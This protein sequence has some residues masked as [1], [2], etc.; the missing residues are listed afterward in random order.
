MENSNDFYASLFSD[1][2]RVDAVFNRQ[3]SGDTITIMGPTSSGKSTAL[4]ELLPPVSNMLLGLNVGD[5]AQ[6]TLIPPYLMLNSRLEEDQVVIRC[7]PREVDLYTD[8]CAQVK[9]KLAK[10]IYDERDL[11]DEFSISDDMVEAI[12]NPVDRRYHVYAF[13]KNS[14][15]LSPLTNLINQMSQEIIKEPEPIATAAMVR[16][17]QLRAKEPRI[18]ILDV[19]EQLIDERFSSN[20]TAEHLLKNWYDDLVAEIKKSLAEHWTYPEKL[21]VIGSP[22]DNNIR[23]LIRKLYAEDSAYSLVI[24]EI[25]YMTRPSER[26]IQEYQCLNE[27]YQHG[28]TIKLSVRDSIGLTQ[29]SQEQEEISTNMD[30]ILK[31]ESNAILFFCASDEQPVVFDLCMALLKE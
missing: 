23:E 6:T 4:T 21:A 24:E 20:K 1:P 16:Y 17:K 29:V 7:T 31:K 9:L 2:K 5:T 28:R 10:Q 30:A 18:K 27:K 19:Y 12:L 14:P 3:L 13:T 25:Q 15:L 8:F 22:K 11:L 26:V